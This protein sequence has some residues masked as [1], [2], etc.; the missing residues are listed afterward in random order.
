[1]ITSFFEESKK[2][3]W[4]SFLFISLSTKIFVSSSERYY[5]LLSIALM[6]LSYNDKTP[7]EWFI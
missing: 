2:N 5:I 7:V 1:M 3:K 6:T 4:F